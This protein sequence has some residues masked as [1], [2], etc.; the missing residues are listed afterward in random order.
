MKKNILIAVLSLL[1]ITS[2][3][4]SPDKD[5]KTIH[6]LEATLKANKNGIPDAAK[7]KELIDAYIKFVKDFPS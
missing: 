1:I 6:D 4:N 5:L 7:T 2:C 3:S